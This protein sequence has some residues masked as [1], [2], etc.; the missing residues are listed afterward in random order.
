MGDSSAGRNAAYR[1]VVLAERDV[2]P[3]W[4]GVPAGVRLVRDVVFKRASRREL[5]RVRQRVASRLRELAD[6]I[7]YM[8]RGEPYRLVTED[9]GYRL[10]LRLPERAAADIEARQVGDEVVLQLGGQRRNYSLPRFLAYYTLTGTRFDDGW[11]RMR[12][13]PSAGAPQEES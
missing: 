2:G 3:E 10:D 4:Q 1:H 6:S 11:F 13:E 8:N 5:V 7:L 9:G 12:F